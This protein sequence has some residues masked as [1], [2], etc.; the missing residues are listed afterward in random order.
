[1]IVWTLVLVGF[2]GVVVV[3]T[4]LQPPD[5]DQTRRAANGRVP[6]GLIEGPAPEPI[7]AVA[8]TATTA[9]IEVDCEAKFATTIPSNIR[10]L[11]LTGSYCAQKPKANAIAST[12]AQNT[13]NGFVG[14]VFY[15]RK[16]GF[17]TDY[18]SL[19]EGENAI[20]VIHIL[21]DGTTQEVEVRVAREPAKE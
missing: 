11:R 17:T 19:V 7:F 9:E 10:Q 14:T 16:D 2:L 15:P 13:T 3:F 5:R 4:L 12:E 20:R 18:I 8:A 21:K 6:A 1:M